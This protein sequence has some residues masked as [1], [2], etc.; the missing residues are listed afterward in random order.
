V[1][2]VTRRRGFL[3]DQENCIGCNACQMACKDLHDLPVGVNWRRVTTLEFG[4]YPRP[5]VVHISMSCNHC[6]RPACAEA[7]P[8]G[9]FT[10]RAEDGAVLHDGALCATCLAC[11]EACPYGAIQRDPT[12]G[13]VGKCDLC[14]DLTS[15]GSE[16]ACVEACPMDALHLIWLDE[17]QVVSLPVLRGL[18]SPSLTE[19]SLRVRP[20]RHG[21]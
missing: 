5:E 2:A 11:V 8:N 16:P 12:T 20:H 1:S 9:G 6:A 15:R 21:V 18:P 10:I 19:P 3:F 13:T 14:G 17:C 4:R 7:C